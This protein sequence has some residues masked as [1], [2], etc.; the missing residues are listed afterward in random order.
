MKNLVR[1]IPIAL[2]GILL[3]ACG[4]G[5]G[6]GSTTGGGNNSGGNTPAPAPAQIAIDTANAAEVAGNVADAAFSA[7]ELTAGNNLFG[8]ASAPNA[9]PVDLAE[10]AAAQLG[11]VEL[12]QGSAYGDGVSAVVVPAEDIPC[13]VDGFATISA[14]IADITGG[15]ISRGDEFD[16]VFNE[17]DE[18]L[19]VI[20]SGRFDMVFGDVQGDLLF[21]GAPYSFSVTVDIGNLTVG[22]QGESFLV[23]GDMVLEVSSQDDISETFRISGNS[24]TINQA[25]VSSTLTNYDITEVVN[26][27]T[28]DYVSDPN[29]T[30]TIPGLGGTV[31]FSTVTS[32]QGNGANYPEVGEMLI[33]GDSDSAVTVVADGSGMVSLLVD[34][35][36]DGTA[37]ETI[38][39]TWLEIIGLQ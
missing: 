15:S 32:F 31:T 34:A 16:I 36:G 10:L 39:T 13:E 11:H 20:L 7:G 9:A 24:L 3:T 25:G 6:G 22:G 5:G 23:D 1:L 18:G 4:G 19:G 37:E 26:F 30:L 2:T 12:V 29:G 33:T 28:L 21:G 35:N 38:V 27:L 17:C 14:D 8:A